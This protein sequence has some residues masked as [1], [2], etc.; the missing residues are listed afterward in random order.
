MGADVALALRSL[1]FH[2]GWAWPVQ[3]TDFET[4]QRELVRFFI[5]LDG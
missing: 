3:P 4:A 1:G 5:G 2:S